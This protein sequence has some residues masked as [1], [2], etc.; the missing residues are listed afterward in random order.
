MDQNERK[1]AMINGLSLGDM[2]HWMVFSGWVIL[3]AIAGMAVLL[4]GIQML[5]APDG[6]EDEKG[7][8]LGEEPASGDGA[9]GGRWGKRTREP[10]ASDGLRLAG[11]IAPPIGAQRPHYRCSVEPVARCCGRLNPRL[12][13]L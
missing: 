13:F 4:G 6:W 8:H 7:F 3:L 12:L 11:T 5:F 10:S 9:A 2:L 1:I